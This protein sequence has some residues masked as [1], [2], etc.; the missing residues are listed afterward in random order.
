MLAEVP[1][2]GG[3]RS[4][5]MRRGGAGGA[6]SVD[7][8][9]PAAYKPTMTTVTRS[10]L[11][12]IAFVSA[13]VMF[14][15]MLLVRWVGTELRVF[16]Y[17]QNGVLVAAFLGLGLGFR[18]ARKP[19]RLLPAVLVLFSR[20]VHGP[21]SP[22]MGHRRGRDAGPGRRSRTR[23]S[24]TR[25]V[26]KQNGPSTS[27]RPSLSYSVAVSLALLAAIAFVFR[28]LGQWLG[29]WMDAY[30]RPIPAYTANILGSLFGIALF[31]M[32]TVAVTRPFSWLAVAGLG[33]AACAA[34][35]DDG[36]IGAGLLGRRGPGAAAAPVERAWHDSVVTL[37]E[38]E[39]RT[40][41]HGQAHPLGPGVQCGEI[42]NVNN[43]GYQSMVEPGPAHMAA[44]PSLYPPGEIRT[45]HY[46]PALRSRGPSRRRC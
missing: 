32:A 38:A 43:V 29:A 36:R 45:S 8:A 42:I 41:G 7:S 1:R 28:P 10:P 46:V 17:L 25:P 21:R 24:G 34:W 13:L 35:S 20:R 14:L 40:A 6:P 16:A 22:E 5:P 31:V 15:E 9:C 4:E 18:S 19:A 26:L 44:H 11:V 39:H 3:R 23:A 2:F 27:A 33:L 30:P 37:P 12:R